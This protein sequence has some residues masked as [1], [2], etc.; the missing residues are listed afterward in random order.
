MDDL[1]GLR[2]MEMRLG[3]RLWPLRIPF[4]YGRVTVDSFAEV[5]LALDA[6]IGGHTV[7]GYAA[8]IAAPKWFEK[9]PGISADESV[10]RL[11]C[12]AIR[13]VEIASGITAELPSLAVLERELT[14]AMA[15]DTTLALAG[16]TALERSFGVALVERAAIDALCRG[17]GL[18]FEQAVASDRLGLAA[19]QGD[20]YRAWLATRGAAPATIGVRHTVGLDDPLDGA[21][22]G[23]GPDDGRPVTLADVIAAT[24]IHRFKVKLG[25]SLAALDRLEAIADVLDAALPRYRISLDAN[26]AFED[27]ESFAA[28]MAEIIRRPRLNKFAAAI[29]YVEQPLHRRLALSVDLSRLALP[30]PV[31]IDESDDGDDAF[32]QA[33]ALGY[34][35][36]SM[37]TCKGVLHGLRNAAQA[38]AAGAFVTAEDLCVQPGIALQQNL[39]AA[40]TIRAADC[41]RNGHHFGPGTAALPADERAAID[42]LH[43]DVYGPEGLRIAAGQI[44]LGSTLAAHGFGT[45][46]TP[47]QGEPLTSIRMGSQTSRSA[48]NKATY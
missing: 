26:E 44:R 5:H 4:H 27:A 9:D 16:L 19:E 47:C 14:R 15:T 25:G 33:L 6:V 40:A 34:A 30:W 11:K 39:A 36:V 41:E 37:K 32:A 38:A 7:T 21:G 48:E 29:A 24:G 42:A 22:A 20:R 45:S 10:D 18:S 43:S 35:G 8:E 23:S 31:I 3:E 12:A 28:V 1:P 13:A 46:L 17:V 2:L